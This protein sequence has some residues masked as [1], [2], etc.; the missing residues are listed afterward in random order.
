MGRGRPSLTR[1]ARPGATATAEPYATAAE[2]VWRFVD[3]IPE[4]SREGERTLAER[5]AGVLGRFEAQVVAAGAPAAAGPPARY[6]LAVAIDQEARRQKRLRL[7]A[8]G[9]AAHSRLFD[10][11]DMSVD[12]LRRFRDT[13]AGAGADYAPVAAFLDG[14]IARISG[15]RQRRETASRSPTL[16]ILGGLVGLAVALAGYAVFLDYRYHAKTYAAYLAD[17]ERLPAVEDPED[18]A[19]L[20]ARLTALQVLSGRVDRAAASAPLAGVFTLDA[21][22]ADAAAD[23]LYRSEV[24]GRLPDAIRRAIGE[25][26]ATEGDPLPLYDALRAW[27][28]L[29]GEVGWAPG[30][31]AGW[32]EE[33]ERLPE[34]AALAP[35][36]AALAAASPGLEAPDPEILAQARAF[37]AEAPEPERAWL[38]LRRLADTRA[39]PAWEPETAVPGLAEVVSRRSGA[40]LGDGM[41]GLFTEAGWT[42]ARREG[43]GIA[44]QRA[45]EV[46]PVVLGTAPPTRN[47][48]P[49]VLMEVLQRETIAH[50]RAWLD[51]LRVRPF[52]DADSAIRISGALAQADSPLGAL[53]REVWRQVGGRD[54]TRSYDMRQE[55]GVAFVPLIQ[56]EESG[57]LS[58]ISSLFAAL[59]VA[60]ASIDFDEE[61]GSERLMS[62]QTLA[63]SVNALTAAPPIV[64]QITEDVLAQTAAA[65]ASF[66]GHPLTRTWQGR[67]YPLCRAVTLGYPFGEGADVPAADVA[68][69]F[70]PDG[71]I[72][73][74][75]AQVADRH[76]DMTG[77]RWRWKPQERLS[78]LTP[79]SAEF[80]QRAAAVSAA[81]FARGRLGGP[82]TVSALAERGEAAMYLGG[83]GVPV[84]ATGDPE[85]IDWP[86][87]D[88]TQGAEVT[89]RSGTQSERL[90]G[91]GPWGLYRI[92]DATR[93]RLRDDGARALVDLR[94]GAGRVFVEMAFDAPANFITARKLME[95]LECPPVL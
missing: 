14:V 85:N 57:K 94:T 63:R 70:G 82:V 6:A 55:I 27:A 80:L 50:W 11:R 20:A 12:Q 60:L 53:I 75:L 30:Y 69:L 81:L 59:N 3:A 7:S 72:P 52:N 88:P 39:L 84:R 65:H 56:Y 46:A 73:G 87:P 25:T 2:E 71:A 17:A 74:F 66:T 36:V 8:W 43:A 22:A 86:G 23:E 34:A 58:E 54:Q 92:L 49:D 26:L 51:D 42:H 19:G 4:I 62:V 32:L 91:E 16:M 68:A 1:A 76:I 83:A 28:T 40:A 45:R 9:A 64:V 67:V 48:T 31:V 18:L 21:Y 5:A 61:R 77:E 35:H 37:A 13:A 29:T 24:A 47:D 89:F 78:G 41:A 93:I 10:G 90:F 44:V 79:E 33:Q 95:G 38:E 15:E